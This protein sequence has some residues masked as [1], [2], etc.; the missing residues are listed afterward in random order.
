MYAMRFLHLACEKHSNWKVNLSSIHLHTLHW[1][2]KV[3]RSY[4]NCCHYLQSKLQIGDDKDQRKS[5]SAIPTDIIGVWCCVGVILH[6][7]SEYFGISVQHGFQQ[8]WDF[9]FYAV[10]TQIVLQLT[11]K[12]CIIKWTI[13]HRTLIHVV[14]VGLAECMH[15]IPDQ[16]LI[17]RT[18][19]DV[20]CF[21]RNLWVEQQTLVS[22]SVG[23]RGGQRQLRQHCDWLCNG[24]W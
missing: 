7:R 5:S 10:R 13:T 17:G 2:D 8:F 3:K 11:A 1:H 14:R 22:H 15:Q 23:K 19:N 18:G 9:P 4:S 21:I 12:N 24:L 20:P 16:F 6:A